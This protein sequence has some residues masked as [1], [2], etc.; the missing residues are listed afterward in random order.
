VRRD[1]ATIHA[2]VPAHI[3]VKAGETVG[4]AF[5]PAKL[6][7]FHAASGR[8]IRTALHEVARHG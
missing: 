1:D 4:L 7:L 2:R 6:S 5:K 3:A 8:A